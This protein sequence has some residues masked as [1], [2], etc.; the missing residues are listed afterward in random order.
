MTVRPLLINS[1]LHI[2]KK[3]QLCCR[4]CLRLSVYTS[5]I[6][7]ALFWTNGPSEII[8]NNW[9]HPIASALFRRLLGS[10][11]LKALPLNP[12]CFFLTLFVDI[13]SGWR[14]SVVF[15]ELDVV[16]HVISIEQW[17]EETTT[18]KA[19]ERAWVCVC[20]SSGLVNK[21]RLFSIWGSSIVV[22]THTSGWGKALGGA[23]CARSS[24]C[25]RVRLFLSMYRTCEL[26]IWSLTA[27]ACLFWDVHS[28]VL[29]VW[30]CVFSLVCGELI[31]RTMQQAGSS[32]PI[33][34]V[35]RGSFS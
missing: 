31:S 17:P 23:V 11:P 12:L 29:G 7:R 25:G 4:F 24:L 14:F 28:C 35:S 15:S 27:H 10:N 13:F 22:I 33:R 20:V 34:R 8:S 16:H 19:S 3:V 18:V 6:I 26:C 1:R 5:H 9:N 30:L 32:D 21:C 2:W